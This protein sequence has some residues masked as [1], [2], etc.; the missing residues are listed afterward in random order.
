[1][2]QLM[3]SFDAVAELGEE[4][5]LHRDGC[6]SNWF[7]GGGLLVFGVREAV[8]GLAQFEVA[9]AD[10]GVEV[11]ITLGACKLSLF[12]DS[13]GLIGLFLHLAVKLF[14]PNLHTGLVASAQEIVDGLVFHLRAHVPVIL[15]HVIWAVVPVRHLG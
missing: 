8:R 7:R 6:Y 14:L 12:A 2:G 3:D 1:M 11:L 4:T 13:R 9:G 10:V 5:W 15:F